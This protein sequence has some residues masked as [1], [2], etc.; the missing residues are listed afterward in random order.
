[1]SIILYF[2]RRSIL[3]CGCSI[4]GLLCDFKVQCVCCI[5]A[6][7]LHGEFVLYLF[8]HAIRC[9]LWVRL[10]WCSSQ[11]LCYGLYYECW[12][13][14]VLWRNSTGWVVSRFVPQELKQSI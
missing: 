8:Q 10:V 3:F 1:M 5:S 2:C 13:R 14:R 7:L 4:I 11:N 6:A 12:T 9:L